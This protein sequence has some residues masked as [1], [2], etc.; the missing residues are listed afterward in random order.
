MRPVYIISGFGA[1][2]RVFQNIEFGKHTPHFIDWKIPHTR[3]SLKAYSRRMMQEIQHP[4][5]VL[6]G[7]S[8]GGMIAIEIAKQMNVAKII[9]I[10][11]VKKRAELP[12]SLRLLA[13]TKLN[14]LI[15]LR[16]YSFLERW[17]NYNLGLK[18]ED[19]KELVRE[20]RKNIDLHYTNWG[21]NQIINWQNAEVPKNIFHLHGSKDHIFPIKNINDV[22]VIEGGG[23]MM[24]MNRADEINKILRQELE[25]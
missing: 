10:S 9:L 8:F 23:H 24:V 12:A 22:Q 1:D 19:Q 17:E 7:L 25:F 21:I 2:K 3:E 16:P 6:I 20:Y 15:N 13:R 14:Q 4:D 18:T 11:S 5:P